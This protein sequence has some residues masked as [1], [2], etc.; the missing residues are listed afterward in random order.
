MYKDQKERCG[1]TEDY[2]Q[3]YE[4][5]DKQFQNFYFQYTKT[6]IAKQHDL[7]RQHF[8][9]KELET[10]RKYIDSG[11][12]PTLTKPNGFAY[13][14]DSLAH[15]PPLEPISKRIMSP[16]LPFMQMKR[17]RQEIDSY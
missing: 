1:R 8:P 4:L 17:L 14:E 6:S 3:Y 12:L 7:L 16:C 10:C 11:K 15:L 5:V 2:K 13:P 9:E